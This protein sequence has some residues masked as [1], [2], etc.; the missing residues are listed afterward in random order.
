MILEFFLI[1]LPYLY[2]NVEAVNKSYDAAGSFAAGTPAHA[3][4]PSNLLE[5]ERGDSVVFLL[6]SYA[7]N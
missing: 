6:Y 4:R 2:S 1:S 3:V 7:V 5:S